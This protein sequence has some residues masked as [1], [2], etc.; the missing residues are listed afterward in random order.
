MAIEIIEQGNDYVPD[1]AAQPNSE[2]QQAQATSTEEHETSTDGGLQDDPQSS[3]EDPSTNADVPE[4]EEDS[5]GKEDDDSSD[6]SEPEYYFGDEPVDVTVDDD[7]RAELD[8]KG[9]DVD[10]IVAEMY[11]KEGNGRPSE[12]SMG[13]L[14]E[15]FGKFSVDAYFNALDIQNNAAVEASKAEIE[16]AEA[17]QEQRWSDVCEMIGGEEAWDEL[18]AFADES[19]T[20]EELQSF[21]EIMESGMEFAQ[22][23]ALIDL[24]QKMASKKG[25]AQVKLLDGQNSVYTQGGDD[26]PM[27][28]EE[29]I[30]ETGKLSQQFPHDKEGYAKAQARL[31]ARRR[32]ALG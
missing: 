29:Y 30:R 31:D 18:S 13:K 5:E 15:A 6:S 22:N 20:D 11:G 1:M 27:S 28:R 10:A 9:I 26:S 12:E 3:T 25:D 24:Q 2:E 7:I 23:L 17:A 8:A 32:A 19:L 21:N 4:P 14:Y 16:A